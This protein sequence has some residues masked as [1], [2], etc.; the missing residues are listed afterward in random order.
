MRLGCRAEQAPNRDNR[1]TLDDRDDATGLPL[2]ACVH[3]QIGT[4]DV[5]NIRR[6]TRLWIDR[7]RPACV[8]DVDSFVTPDDADRSARQ[9]AARLSRWD[10][11]GSRPREAPWTSTRRVHTTSN[12]A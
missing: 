8:A 6:A 10:D 2:R 5:D 4:E 1:V 12:V 11:D 7:A 9:L 3:W